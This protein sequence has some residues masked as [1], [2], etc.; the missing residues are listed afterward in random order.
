MFQAQAVDRCHRLGQTK[1]V[2]T[3]RFVIKAT[4]EE[5]IL[6]LQKRKTDLANMSLGQTMSK[7]ELRKQRLEDMNLL[8]N[9]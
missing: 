9:P 5:S 2:A 7:A 3:I 4:I 8:L 6:K 1:E